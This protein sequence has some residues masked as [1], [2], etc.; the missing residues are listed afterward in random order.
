MK[1][2]MMAATGAKGAVVV[3]DVAM[4]EGLTVSL[5]S[6]H[7]LKLT[8]VCTSPRPIT[9]LMFMPSSLMLSAISCFKTSNARRSKRLVEEHH[10]TLT[11]I[12]PASPKW[13]RT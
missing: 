4:A 7:N 3:G 9:P 6:P 5:M 2:A 1:D 10:L 11:L 8:S 12:A 13:V